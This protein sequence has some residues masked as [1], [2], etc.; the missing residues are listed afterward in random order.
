MK[1]KLVNPFT[2]TKLDGSTIVGGLL[3]GLFIVIITAAVQNIARQVGMKT[4]I[5]TTIAGAPLFDAPTVT[6]PTAP[7]DNFV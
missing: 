7:T 5:D 3:W 2:A 6:G 4:P 1:F